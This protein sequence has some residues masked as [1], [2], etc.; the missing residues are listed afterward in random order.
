M[1]KVILIVDDEIKIIEVIKLYLE[2]EGYDVIWA[3]DG[4][5]ALYK[6]KKYSVDLIILDLMLPDIS[7]EQICKSIRE[8]SDVPIIMLTAKTDEDSVLNGYSL[9]S[10]DYIIK[11]FRPKELVAKVNVLLKRIVNVEKTGMCFDGNLII[12]TKGS[13]VI[14]NNEE[15]NLTPS[16]YRILIMLA[17]NPQRV[18][19]REELLDYL[20]GENIYVYDRI[21]D[22]HIKNLRAKIEDDSK[23]P[24]YIKTIRSIG[25]KFDDK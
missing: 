7:G 20:T 19:S 4:S 14:K 6:Y 15:V 9:G 1:K 21:I 24:K 11:P 12:D 22:T 5:D 8:I 18:F 10:D 23:N 17:E 2:N 16:E 3:T 25:Y 13:K